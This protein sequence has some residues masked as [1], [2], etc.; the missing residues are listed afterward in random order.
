MTPIGLALA[1][2]RDRPLAAVLGVALLAIGTGTLVALLLFDAQFRERLGRD[3]AGI[4]IVVGAK[5]SPLQLILSA[6]HHVD[7]PTGNIRLAD[8]DALAAHPMVR[9]AV[10]I[11]LGDSWRGF[12][13]V[14]TVPAFLDHRDATVGDGRVWQAPFEAVLG[15]AV[16]GRTGL[17][18]GDRFESDHGLIPGGPRGH[19]EEHPYTVT[20]ILAPTGGVVDRLILTA[21]DSVWEAHEQDDAS[22]REVTAV[23]VSVKSPIAMVTLP[24]AINATTAM[25][26]AVPAFETARL[27]ALLGV[28]LDVLRG[29]GLIL[30]AGAALG[31][32]VSLTTALDRRR[33]DMALLRALGAGRAW[34]AGVLLV[35][36]TL[37]SAV[38]T[39]L[40]LAL[41]HAAMEVLAA[42]VG[43]ARDLGI[44]GALVTP[45]EG[46]AVLGCV[47][48]GP[49]AALLPAI[50]AYRTEVAA[51]LATR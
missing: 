10:P 21:L 24:R 42:S 45:A 35:E 34:V 11:G 15:A 31:V 48:L 4:D 25:Q 20:G 5:G 38:G 19:H 39:A 16:A 29:F 9:R 8:A 3:A 12:R 46:W 44:H 1:Y 7:V 17:R 2:L 32:F 33:R 36:G 13:L 49:L 30:L 18:P 6:V 51:T 22:A 14:G 27:F 43:Q 50:R 28:G 40:G 41:G 47:M 37:L 23:L 26:A